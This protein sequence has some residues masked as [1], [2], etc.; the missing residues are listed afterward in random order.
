MTVQHEASGRQAADDAWEI[1]KQKAALAIRTL[2]TGRLGHDGQELPLRAY[3]VIEEVIGVKQLTD[4]EK[5]TIQVHRAALSDMWS[6]GQLVAD[7]D[8]T[9]KP[10]PE[11]SPIEDPET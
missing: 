3:D 7:C 1:D 6:S 10:G 4:E 9:L 5:R 11:F 8:W 2:F